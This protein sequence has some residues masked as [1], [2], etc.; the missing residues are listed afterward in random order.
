MMFSF[1][2]Q[3]WQENREQDDS[4]RNI[5]P[6]ESPAMALELLLFGES[7]GRRHLLLDMIV[8]RE[9]ISPRSLQKRAWLLPSGIHSIRAVH[10]RRRAWPIVNLFSKGRGHDSSSLGNLSSRSRAHQARHS[11]MKRECLCLENL[12]QQGW[13]QQVIRW[14]THVDAVLNA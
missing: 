1:N 9:I 10:R 11:T 4:S 12:S 2:L 7:R 13:Q 8:F 6:P 5:P 14:H 3:D